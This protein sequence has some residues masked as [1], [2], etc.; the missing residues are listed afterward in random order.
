MAFDIK[1]LFLTLWL[2]ASVS[3][4]LL[5]ILY[6]LH[7]NI[8]G[9]RDWLVSKVLMMV[10]IPIIL[11]RD[12]THIL[13][14]GA[15]AGTLQY[16][17]VSFALVGHLK[18]CQRP[19]NWRLICG[20]GGVFCIAFLSTYMGEAQLVRRVMIY[21]LGL[22][23]LHL[24]NSW[25]LLR[26]N[27]VQNM[28]QKICSAAYFSHGLFYYGYVVAVLIAPPE[29]NHLF[30]M[31][32]VLGVLV[33]EGIIQSILTT[34]CIMLMVAEYLRQQLKERIEDLDVARRAAEEAN[35]EQR[36]FLAMVSHEFRTPL[37]IIDA[38]AMVVGCNVSAQD[39]ESREELQR[40]RRVVVRL[41]NLVEA[42]LADD[43]L[44]S[45]APHRQTD[46][47]SLRSLLEGLTA[48]HGVCLDFQDSEDIVL[49]AVP[50]LLPIAI[51]SLIDNANKYGRTREGTKVTCRRYREVGESAHWVVINVADDGP[52]IPAEILPH[53]AEKYYRA[54]TTLHKPGAGLGLYLV[55][56][57]VKLHGGYLKLIQDRETVFSI[58]LPG[59]DGGRDQTSEQEGKGRS[60]GEEQRLWGT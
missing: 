57:I 2:V 48:E 15:L 13:I 35:L 46:P 28:S 54:P 38:S 4:L 21:A 47:L 14:Y 53:V 19:V 17:A 56:R 3:A 50:H 26:W 44:E 41:S 31:G 36:N 49:A 12:S 1:T 33:M 30:G 10:S 45:N 39:D 55:Q 60:K 5:G 27:G 43:W 20:A 42:C 25:V 22:G 16:L 24:W 9:A 23:S 6:R 40:I 58:R 18:F 34:G 11:S 29:S 7:P 37:S 59:A 32:M 8:P 52:G 51:S